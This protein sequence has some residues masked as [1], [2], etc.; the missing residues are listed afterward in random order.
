MS[1]SRR[2]VLAMA[3]AAFA[4]AA[5]LAS[6]HPAKP[7]L[8]RTLAKGDLVVIFSGVGGG[9]YRYHEPASGAGSACRSADTTYNEADSYRWYYRFV[10]PPG[11]GTSDAPAAVAGGGQITGTEQ[12]LQCA[13]SAALTS[14]CTQT[15]RTPSGVSA[16]DLA[17]PNIV[18]GAAGGLVTVGAL[19][20]LI[21]AS[22]QASCTGVGVL[23][24]NPVQGFSQL[25][26]AVSIDRATLSATGDVTRHFT[27]AGSG[28]YS[29]LALS[30]SCNSGGCDVSDCHDSGGA[31]SGPPTSCS[32]NESYSGTIEVRIVR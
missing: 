11:G 2:L 6:A 31:G 32:Y 20:E 12:L 22:P 9:S 18:V 10:L 25:Q 26:A 7:R 24:L 28:L 3:L 4:A 27:M 15:L 19:G 14:T 5:P 23:A 1:M 21:P 29:G 30:G 17:Y 13:G 16:S 8:S